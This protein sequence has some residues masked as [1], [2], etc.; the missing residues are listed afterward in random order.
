M[1]ILTILAFIGTMVMTEMLPDES[2]TRPGRTFYL[3]Y[4]WWW[5]YLIVF[6]SFR[7]V[8]KYLNYFHL[9][10]WLFVVVYVIVRYVMFKLTNSYFKRCRERKERMDHVRWQRAI[11]RAKAIQS[12]KNKYVF[13][14]SCFFIAIK[15]RSLNEV[16]F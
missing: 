16:S 10:T 15:Q 12:S 1:I 11:D 2:W 7:S 14:I 9:S 3:L 6:V 13:I 8:I 5:V 4:V